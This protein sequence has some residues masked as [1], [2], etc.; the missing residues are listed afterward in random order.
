VSFTIT[1]RCDGCTACGRQ[2]PVEAI[3]GDKGLMH[4]VDAD[5]CIDCGVCGHICALG[6]ILNETGAQAARIPR[7]ERPR[8][9]VSIDLCNGCAL[10]VTLCPEDAR[11]LAGPR[12]QGASY[13]AHPL[14]C[15]SCG[16]CLRVCIKHAIRLTRL[17]VRAFDPTTHAEALVRL[18]R[19]VDDPAE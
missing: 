2:C 11:A 14:R 15:V 10:C 19:P 3:S 7:D 13:L 8:P 17:D 6:A 5:L 4:T 1:V 16:E 9:V 18:V 12:F